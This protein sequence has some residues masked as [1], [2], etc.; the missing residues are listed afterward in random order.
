MELKWLD[1]MLYR[2]DE[3]LVAQNSEAFSVTGYAR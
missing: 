2:R 3:A 1:V